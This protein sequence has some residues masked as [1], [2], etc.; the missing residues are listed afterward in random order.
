MTD[1]GAESSIGADVAA[2]PLACQ[3]DRFY[4]P[5][6]ERYLNCAY[7]APLLRT[8]ERAA[9]D[10]LHRW[11]R[12]HALGA[13]AYFDDAERVRT[14]FAKLIGAAD[15]GRV[16]IVP[17][18]SYGI[19][20][21]ARNVAVRTGANVVIADGQFPSNVYAW[22][23]LCAQGAA[24]LRIVKRPPGGGWAERLLDAIDRRTAVVALGTVDWVDGTLFDLEAI[25]ARARDVGAA[26]VLDGI[27]SVGALPFDL[28]RVRPDLLVCS[29]YK[30]LL[31]PMGVGLCYLGER[32]A[33]GEPLEE[34]WLGRY[35]SEDFSALTDYTEM[36][37]PGARR[38]DAGGRAHFVLLPMLAAALRQLLD[39]TPAGVQEYCARLAAP[40]LAELAALGIETAADDPHAMHLFAVRLPKTSTACIRTLLA[41]HRVHVSVRSEK[42]RISPNV[43]NTPADFG[44]L[45][46]ALREGAAAC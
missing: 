28:Q 32:F 5:R 8:V 41:R 44:A 38:F 23:R 10:A 36:Y 4:L 22:R 30:W 14:L 39:W 12:P 45:I 42:L 25:G 29:S 20:I 1:G 7:G 13:D 19:A 6:G 24:E 34:T 33:D 15:S 3:A 40:A 26:Y 46:A 18:V 43:Y 16:A 17:G 21:A 31:G 37:Q 35:G 27:Q 11:R 9:R 2:P